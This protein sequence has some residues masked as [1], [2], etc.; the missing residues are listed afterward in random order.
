M[1]LNKCR[2]IRDESNLNGECLILDWWVISIRIFPINQGDML[3]W[4]K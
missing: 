2:A 1:V 4:K 3:N